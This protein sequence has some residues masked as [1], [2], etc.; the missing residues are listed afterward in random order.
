MQ[1]TLSLSLALLLTATIKGQAPTPSE[2]PYRLLSSG[3]PKPNSPVSTAGYSISVDRFLDRPDIEKLICQVLRKEK[4]PKSSILGVSIFYK[5]DKLFVAVGPNLEKALLD[6]T[7][8]YYIWNV[9]LPD[10]R[11]RLWVLR[12]AEGKAFDVQRGYEFDHTKACD[13][14][15]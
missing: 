10:V 13:P 6:Q 1:V 11:E 5:L 8:A 9:D 7:L 2:I 15:K 14:P 12:D 4:P 3:T